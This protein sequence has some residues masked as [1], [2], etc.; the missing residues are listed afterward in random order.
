VVTY[1]PDVAKAEIHITPK[2]KFTISG[3]KA[4]RLKFSY[5]VN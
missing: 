2:I 1:S 4:Y 3:P 5:K